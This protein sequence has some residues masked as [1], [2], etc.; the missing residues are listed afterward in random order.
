MKI[1]L[2]GGPY[3]GILTNIKEDQTSLVINGESYIKYK[4]MF[5]HDSILED[6]DK[7]DKALLAFAKN[8]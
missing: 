8:V 1:V 7:I 2:I 6:D 3:E 4:N 5:V